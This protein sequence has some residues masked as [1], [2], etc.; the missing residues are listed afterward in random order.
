MKFSRY[1]TTS[2][3]NKFPKNRYRSTI[4][5]IITNGRDF[6]SDN[7]FINLICLSD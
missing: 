7:L 3:T 5:N 4:C 1:E 2:G 6:Y